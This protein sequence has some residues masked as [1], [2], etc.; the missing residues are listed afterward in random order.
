M[1]EF[2]VEEGDIKKIELVANGVG[3]GPITPASGDIV[4]VYNVSGLVYVLANNVSATDTP[5]ITAV[6][7][8]N[9]PTLDLDIYDYVYTCKVSNFVQLGRF[10]PGIF[11]TASDH[12]SLGNAVELQISGT[13]TTGELQLAFITV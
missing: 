13:F 12:A 11:N 2:I 3:L 10:T 5:I 9:T 4:F 8:R 7:T 6:A 1:A